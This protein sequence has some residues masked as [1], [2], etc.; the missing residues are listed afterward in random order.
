MKEKVVLFERKEDCCGCYACYSICSKDAISFISDE[1]G[2]MYPY[3][4]DNKC[5]CCHMCIDVCP[6]KDKKRK[7]DFID[8]SCFFSRLW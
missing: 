3:I 7:C 1:E 2:F 6:I 5:I 4:D 8:V